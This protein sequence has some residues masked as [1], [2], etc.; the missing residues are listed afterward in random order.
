MSYKYYN[1][2]KSFRLG[3]EFDIVIN[4]LTS[5]RGLNES[6][7]EEIIIDIKKDI[8]E[9]L[10]NKIKGIYIEKNISKVVNVDAICFEVN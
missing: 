5:Y 3:L 4:E 8:R 7:I 2:N 9:F 10:T 1:P 6:K